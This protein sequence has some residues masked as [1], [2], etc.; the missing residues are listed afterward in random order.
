[1]A[2]PGCTAFSGP[3]VSKT[4]S[5]SPVLMLLQSHTGGSLESVKGQHR[6]GQAFQQQ[7]APNYAYPRL[8]SMISLAAASAVYRR[9]CLGA[10]ADGRRPI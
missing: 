3:F 4:A 1:M 8:K 6:T 10:R 2:V 7:P 5:I 9:P